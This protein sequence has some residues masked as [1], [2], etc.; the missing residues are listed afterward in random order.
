MKSLK[1]L[2]L[3]L[4]MVA[5]GGLPLS[6]SATGH[7][8][9][10]L[11]VS[12]AVDLD[13]TSG[14]GDITVHTGGNGSVYV[15]AKIHA[16]NSWFFGSGNA[17]EKI[18][19]IEKNPPVEQQGNTI[20][21]G[22]SD[23][24][25]LYRNISI[26]YDITVP[27]QTKV[28]SHTGSGDQNISGIQLPLAATTGSGNITVENV[29]ADT[30]IRSGSGDL[31]I[32]SVKGVLNAETGSGNIRAQEV[33][34]EIIANT[35]SGDVEM[36]QSA[37]GDVKVETGSGNVKLYGVK[38]GLRA[39][40]GSGDIHAEGEATHDWRLGA[41]SGNITLR[42]PAHAT[43]NLD[44]RTSSGTLNIHHEITM[45]G[46]ISRNHVQGKA[47]GGGVLLDLHTGSGDIEI[48]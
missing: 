5:L 7:F 31:K 40:T 22:R 45:Q 25:E 8:E 13:V 43:F 42:L 9:R 48:D 16:S 47:G 3:L 44:A 46:S 33:A 10:T 24:H 1:S 4:A 23:D 37:A 32:N 15:S 34:G 11:Q 27:A 18:Q 30:R 26:D 35:G 36:H 41:G 17:E 14:S 29:S 39:E 28:T 38:G 6:A 20:R 12:G 19:R 21:I 2:S